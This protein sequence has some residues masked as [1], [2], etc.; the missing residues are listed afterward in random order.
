MKNI[1]F[2]FSFLLLANIF[3]A[4]ENGHFLVELEPRT[5]D[6]E[7]MIQAFEG[8]KAIPML[9]NNIDGKE[10]SISDYKGKT[11]LLWFWNLG[12]DRCIQ[13]ISTLNKLNAELPNLEIISF[14]DEPSAEIRTFR[15]T[16]AIDFNVIGS[17]KM[18]AEGPYSGEL[19]YPKL[20][21]VDNEGIIKWVFPS[22]DFLSEKFDLYKIV[23]TLY[24]Q[25]NP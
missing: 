21:I 9:A 17:S 19:G 22:K 13:E 7:A 10:I 25:L 2:V 15:E 23:K 1:G 6:V 12:C 18:L 3:F 14:A 8:T 5:P 20:F 16:T 4:Q 11:V 24:T